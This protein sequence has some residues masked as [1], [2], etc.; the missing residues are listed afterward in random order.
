LGIDSH[1]RVCGCFDAVVAEKSGGFVI[2]VTVIIPTSA[3]PSHPSTRII[4]ETIASV[5]E[6]LPDAP[7]IVTCDGPN[8]SDRNNPYSEFCHRVTEKFPRTLIFADHKH[9]SGMMT[10]V[11]PRISTPLIFY[12]EDDWEILPNIEWEALAKTIL[13]DDANYIRLYAAKR[14]PPCHEPMMRERVVI[15]D[16]PF[17]KTVQFSANPHLASTEWYRKIEEQHLRGKCDYI[18]NLLHGPIGGAPWEEYKLLIY[19]PSYGDFNRVLH[20]DG[21]QP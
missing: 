6:S 18:E 7:I 5:R 9:Q 21:D 12:V 4:D 17:V 14:V 13:D 1:L 15:N 8:E 19:N 2:P 11:L 20:L 16:V 3:R 10:S